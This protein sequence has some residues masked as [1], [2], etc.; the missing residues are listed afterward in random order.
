MTNQAKRDAL[1]SALSSL[2]A[3]NK[4]LAAAN[5]ALALAEMRAG[6]ECPVLT[7]GGIV[8][9]VFRMDRD[10]GYTPRIAPGR[11]GLQAELIRAIKETIIYRTSAVEGA[12]RAYL[13][14]VADAAAIDS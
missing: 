3:A 5:R 1:L 10:T 12:H 9:E 6:Q 14:E 8:V 11:A 4:A 7:F 13:Q 2:E